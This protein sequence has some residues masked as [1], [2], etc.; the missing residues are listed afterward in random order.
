MP[1]WSWSRKAGRCGS[2]TASNAR[3]A[4]TRTQPARLTHYAGP[5]S[6][7]ATHMYMDTSS[8]AKASWPQLDLLLKML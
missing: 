8:G 5:V 7:Q 1:A 4:P 3:R 6:N 2:V